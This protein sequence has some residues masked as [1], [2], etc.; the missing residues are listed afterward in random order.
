[1]QQI[2]VVYV[3]P[4][5]DH[6]VFE[7]RVSEVTSRFG[8]RVVLTMGPAS[9]LTRVTRERVLLSQ[10]L[11]NIVVVRDGEVIAEAIGDLPVREIESLL[12]P[13]VE[14]CSEETTATAA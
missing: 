9:Q 12:G 6:R 4:T 2:D 8:S 5:G 10:M 14:R 3:R 11:P 7:A 13:A 1:M